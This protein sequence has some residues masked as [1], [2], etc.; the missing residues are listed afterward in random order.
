MNQK[1]ITALCI[2]VIICGVLF[3]PTLYRYDHI[4]VGGNT[5]P[6]RMNRITG[7]TQ[8]Y[9][10]DKWVSEEQHKSQPIIAEEL[11][12]PEERAKIQGNAGFNDHGTSFTG[13]IY[14]GSRDWT[15]TSIIL[16][17]TAYDA[18]KS[19][20]DASAF[21]DQTGKS[22]PNYDDIMNNSIKLSDLTPTPKKW[23][24]LFK[25]HV[26]INPLSTGRIS[27]SVESGKWDV[28]EWDIEEIKGYRG[29]NK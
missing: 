10:A 28:P 11:F 7:Y 16:R 2:T 1:S 8:V 23:T 26:I 27:I 12:P 4:M 13:E 14:N 21:L 9:L 6:V 24:R 15:I 25:T 22:K 19:D 18:P 3:W 20:T 5:F 29:I 17:V